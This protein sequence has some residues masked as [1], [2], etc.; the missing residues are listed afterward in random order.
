MILPHPHML[1]L[2][3]RSIRGHQDN[4]PLLKVL[5]F[6]IWLMPVINLCRRLSHMLVPLLQQ[7]YIAMLFRFSCSLG[8]PE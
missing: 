7:A 2:F 5:T 1:M 4:A 3:C 6:R 8:I